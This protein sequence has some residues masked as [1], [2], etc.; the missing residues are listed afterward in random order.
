[1]LRIWLGLPG[2]GG[3]AGLA[4]G[5]VGV[6][7]PGRGAAVCPKRNSNKVRLYPHQTPPPRPSTAAAEQCVRRLKRWTAP[8][9][10]EEQ[11]LPPSLLPS[12]HPG[13]IPLLHPTLGT[14]QKMMRHT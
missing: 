8:D 4:D 6:I 12:A 3:P 10:L 14:G 7:Y 5:L 11:G 1:M 13:S 2:W 9:S